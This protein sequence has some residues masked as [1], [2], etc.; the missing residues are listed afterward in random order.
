MSSIASFIRLPES[1]LGALRDAAIPTKGRFGVVKDRYHDY[2]LEHGR[3]VVQYN[4]PG[5]VLA[6]LLPDREEK[7]GIDLAKS[8]HDELA[9][10]LTQA[11]GATHY[12]LTEAHRAA[13][14]DRLDPQGFSEAELREYFNEFNGT[15]ESE[16]ARAMLDG[17]AALHQ[18]LRQIHSSS[19]VLLIIG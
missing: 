18:C 19:L 9:T 11:R 3:A 15:N 2:L 17:I 1:A 6:T 13:F 12:V 10:F 14:C 5:Y 7:H 8:P 16:V 4:W